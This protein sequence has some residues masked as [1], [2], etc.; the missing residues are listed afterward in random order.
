MSEFMQSLAD[1]WHR[2]AADPTAQTQALLGGILA[3]LSTIALR[4]RKSE[5]VKVDIDAPKGEKVSIT[6]GDEETR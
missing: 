5:R 6:I 4:K 2:L 1:L 3:A